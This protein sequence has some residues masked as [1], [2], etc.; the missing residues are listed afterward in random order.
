MQGSILELIERFLVTEIRDREGN[1]ERLHMQREGARASISPILPH[2]DLND[3]DKR[4]NRRC[5]YIRYADDL[6]VFT[7]T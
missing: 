6:V 2:F 3:F 1:G 5:R 7:V 4:V